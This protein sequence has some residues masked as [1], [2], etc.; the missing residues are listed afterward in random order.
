M[1]SFVYAAGQLMNIYPEIPEHVESILPIPSWRVP[2]VSS[3][4]EFRVAITI[5]SFN[6][7]SECIM[8]L[9]Y[10]DNTMLAVDS[11]FKLSHDFRT[12]EDGTMQS[13]TPTC[14]YAE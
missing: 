7:T 10:A 1:S 12:Y 13:L 14:K 4:Q 6:S 9:V 11:T 2:V 5:Y 3:E 8:N